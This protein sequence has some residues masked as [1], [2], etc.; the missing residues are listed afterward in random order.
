MD[1]LT[2]K[3]PEKRTTMLF[4]FF[5]DLKSDCDACLKYGLDGYDW[6]VVRCLDYWAL[7]IA[8]VVKQLKVIARIKSNKE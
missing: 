3:T 1:D 8:E 5:V 7:E 2:N 6:R 4:E